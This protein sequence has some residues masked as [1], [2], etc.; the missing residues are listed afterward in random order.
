M[1]FIICI[2][3][4]FLIGF[5]VSSV[6]FQFTIEEIIHEFTYGDLEHETKKDK[7]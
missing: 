4:G 2:V 3:V 1:L 5:F 6:F 7:E